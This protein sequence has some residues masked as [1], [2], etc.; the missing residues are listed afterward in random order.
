MRSAKEHVNELRA[1]PSHWVDTA[2]VVVF[3]DRFEFVRENCPEPS[4]LLHSLEAHG[5]LAIGL[6]GIQPSANSHGT[7]LV[8]VFPEYEGQAWTHLHMERL[9]RIVSIGGVL[10]L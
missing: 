2:I 1:A 3:P 9:R 10:T 8:K 5:G 7:F 4:L 6:A